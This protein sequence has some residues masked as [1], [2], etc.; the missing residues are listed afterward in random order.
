MKNHA[1][2]S[3]MLAF[4][5]SNNFHSDFCFGHSTSPADAEM[6]YTTL[7][8]L[9]WHRSPRKIFFCD[10]TQINRPFFTVG[11]RPRPQ[12]RVWIACARFASVRIFS[13]QI[14]HHCCVWLDRRRFVYDLSWP[15]SSG[16]YVVRINM[17]SWTRFHVFRIN[18]LREMRSAPRFPPLER[19][20][21]NL[22][23]AF[24]INTW[25]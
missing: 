4:S 18:Y 24:W 21:C 17:N 7:C 25:V 11:S 23:L 1:M 6:P 15:K 12:C 22:I 20:C 5:K 19:C 14:Q 3:Q 16:P 2:I 9:N 13:C 10:C 8:S